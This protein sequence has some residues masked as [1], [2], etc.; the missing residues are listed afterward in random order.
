MNSVRALLLAALLAPGSFA[1]A[2]NLLPGEA[3]FRQHCIGCHSIGCNRAGPKLQGIFGR[4][5]GTVPDFKTYSPALVAS[6]IVWSDDTL[7][8]FLHAPTK[9]V[10]GTAMS[11][12]RVDDARDRR[13]I[14]DYVRRQDRSI[15][16][17]F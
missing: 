6:G 13:A 8:A 15:D 2:Q 14:I 10:P 12:V 4:K 11:I 17:C 16:L 9:L 5:A 7:D 3:A 1:Q